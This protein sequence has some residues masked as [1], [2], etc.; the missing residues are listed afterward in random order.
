M[1][2]AI[3]DFLNKL[4]EL[5]Q[6]EGQAAANNDPVKFDERFK[7]GDMDVKSD[8]CMSCRSSVEE[9]S[10]RFKSSRWHATCFSCSKCRRE[11]SQELSSATYD[12]A[13]NK[14]LCSSCT[15]PGAIKGFEPITQLQQYTF[16]LR[17][18][19]KR[20]FSL[21]RVKGES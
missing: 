3:G 20:L 8:L 19:L 7:V 5:G 9:S 18:A 11:L 16:L 1:K 13:E 14:I 21:L 6:S 12:S 15:R 10:V 2:T 17:V 4:V